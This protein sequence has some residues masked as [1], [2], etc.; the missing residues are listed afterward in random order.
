MQRCVILGAVCPEALTDTVAPDPLKLRAWSSMIM[1]TEDPDDRKFAN[2]KG[3]FI[4]M[5]DE[6]LNELSRSAGAYANRPL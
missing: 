3:M 1:G 5:L 6:A 4:G 2:S